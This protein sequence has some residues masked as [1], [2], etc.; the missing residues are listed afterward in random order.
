MS[1]K[2]LPHLSI[3]DCCD[4]QGSRSSL[5]EPTTPYHFYDPNSLKAVGTAFDAAWDALPH[6]GKG[7]DR[8]P[9]GLDLLIGA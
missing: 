4:L 3:D 2:T 9:R 1:A 7:D 8:I 5:D 6:E